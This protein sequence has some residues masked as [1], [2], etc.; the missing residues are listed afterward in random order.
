MR[1][2]TWLVARL[3][4]LRRVLDVRDVD[5]QSS[6]GR[7]FDGSDRSRCGC[8]L[9]CNGILHCHLE[10]PHEGIGMCCT[11]LSYASGH[12]EGQAAMTTRP[13][14]PTEIFAGLMNVEGLCWCA[15]WYS[16]IDGAFA[17]DLM[18]LIGE[19]MS[20]HGQW[21]GG[22]MPGCLRRR[23]RH[24]PYTAHQHRRAPPCCTVVLLHPRLPIWSA[25]ALP[26]PVPVPISIF[27]V[28]R[29]F[30]ATRQEPPSHDCLA[31]PTNVSHART[32][33]M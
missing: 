12:C 28:S 18:I 29:W 10:M 1:S 25:P 26:V 20:E 32:A 3:D 2:E 15:A 6:C 19:L 4:L 8:K 33:S 11:F 13:Q 17:D 5:V 31:K 22:L 14:K 30:R 21:L 23:G 27:C 24:W 7:L 9:D 16:D